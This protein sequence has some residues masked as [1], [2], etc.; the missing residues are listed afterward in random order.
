MA[1]ALR[2]V[3]LSAGWFLASILWLLF[4][5][6]VTCMGWFIWVG[7]EEEKGIASIW[8]IFAALAGG[9]AFFLTAYLAGYWDRIF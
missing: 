3:G 8:F 7:P 2:I 5:F 4:V 9:G 1:R 6:A